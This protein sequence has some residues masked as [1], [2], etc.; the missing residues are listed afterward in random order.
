MRFR[1]RGSS[2][3][4]GPRAALAAWRSSRI[5]HRDFP[6]CYINNHL[7]QRMKPLAAERAWAGSE[8][9]RARSRM[10]TH[11]R[12][13]VR[14]RPMRRTLAQCG[15][16]KLRRSGPMRVPPRGFLPEQNGRGSARLAQDTGG[17]GWDRVG[18]DQIGSAARSGAARPA[19]RLRARPGDEGNALA[20]GAGASPAEA[21]GC[22][23]SGALPV[24]LQLLAGRATR[25]AGLASRQHSTAVGRVCDRSRRHRGSAAEWTTAVLPPSWT[26]DAGWNAP[27]PQMSTI[28]LVVRVILS[29]AKEDSMRDQ[30]A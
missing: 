2:G 22:S 7:Q 11:R 18:P 24:G 19:W 1:S 4:L 5:R 3:H 15:A 25:N 23:Q 20:S 6:S 26:L 21:P 8:R 30:L 16:P 28:S 12:L 29:S 27:P 13:T 10:A 14:I 17:T 9:R